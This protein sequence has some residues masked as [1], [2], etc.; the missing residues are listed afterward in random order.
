MLLGTPALMAAF[1]KQLTPR[2]RNGTSINWDLFEDGDRD[3]VIVLTSFYPTLSSKLDEL[4]KTFGIRKPWCPKGKC[5]GPAFEKE[6]AAAIT[7]VLK[8]HQEQGVGSGGL[9]IV[10]EV[11]EALGGVSQDDVAEMARTTAR[12][13][14]PLGW[15]IM[16]GY[17]PVDVGGGFHN[18][19]LTLRSYQSQ[20][21]RAV[22]RL[23][24]MGK[25]VRGVIMESTEMPAHANHIRLNFKLPVWDISTLGRCLMKAAPSYIEEHKKVNPQ[26]LDLYV[27][28]FMN[29]AFKQC[30]KAWWP[31][32][33]TMKKEPVRLEPKFGTQADGTLKFFE[34]LDNDT[35]TMLTCTGGRPGPSKYPIGRRMDLYETGVT[36][37]N[38]MGVVSPICRET[39]LCSC[40]ATSPAPGPGCPGPC[41]G[42]GNC[43]GGPFGYQMTVPMGE[44]NY[45]CGVT[46]WLCATKEDIPPLLRSPSRFVNPGNGL[47][48]PVE[49]NA[50][51]AFVP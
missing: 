26:N 25:T 10:A 1:A 23:Q 50:M 40:S 44:M 22:R 37:G 8:I 38:G 20:F 27:D 9:R 13:F 45:P 51:G 15:N 49:H 5:S 34:N 42:A 7:E 4:L 33:E 16:P 21:V 41:P 39:E 32:T 43:G 14:V 48:C 46:G 11:M 31:D 35:L 29:E 17:I 3:R 24:A 2:G 12:N 18:T 19:W 47:A 28:L 6:L 30:M 36:T